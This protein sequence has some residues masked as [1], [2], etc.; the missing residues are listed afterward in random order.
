[1]TRTAT[2]MSETARDTKNMFWTLCRG[3]YVNMAQMTKMLP[4]IVNI[5]IV[6]KISAIIIPLS[7]N[8][9]ICGSI[10][11]VPVLQMRCYH[12]CANISSLEILNS[13]SCAGD[14]WLLSCDEFW[15]WVLHWEVSLLL[16]AVL[17]VVKETQIEA[18]VVCQPSNWFADHLNTKHFFHCIFS[19]SPHYLV[20]VDFTHISHN[21]LKND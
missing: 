4:T 2:A 6:P 13:D 21:T 9:P 11:V 7:I 3:L 15:R 14:K 10:V 18:L 12:F 8:S 19:V 5:M 16:C 17:N 1:M 20:R